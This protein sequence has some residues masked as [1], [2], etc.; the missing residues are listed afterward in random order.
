M[1][2]NR[3][4]RTIVRETFISERLSQPRSVKVSLP[5]GYNELLT[6]PAIYCQDGDDFIQFGRIVT[7]ANQLILNEGMEPAIIVAVEVDK[8]ERTAEYDPEGSRFADY[9]R[10]FV[11]ELVPALE[12][13]YP[14]RRDRDHR[15]AA[16]DSL[17]GTVSLHLALEWPQTFRRV[18]SLSGAFGP[19]T[20]ER[21]SQEASLEQLDLYML[22]GLQEQAVVTKQGTFDFLQ[23]NR[24]TSRMLTD[25]GAK[26]R[27]IE[28]PGQHLW[29]FWQNELPDAL[30]H[31]LRSPAGLI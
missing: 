12:Q 29:G 16:G 17:G 21:I 13:K 8:S 27:Y 9:T 31:Y 3:P 18:I 4:K 10:F 14:L 23:A 5:P 28:K 15:I 26:V 6:Y 20:W 1:N 11:E 2:S 30:L 24:E 25:R 7:Q 22:I 19:A